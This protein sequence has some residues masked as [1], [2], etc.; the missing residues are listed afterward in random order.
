M[1]IFV[2]AHF[3]AAVFIEII[4]ATK[5]IICILCISWRPRELNIIDLNKCGPRVKTSVAVCRCFSGG[6]VCVSVPPWLKHTNDVCV[7][8]SWRENGEPSFIL[9]ALFFHR[10]VDT[11]TTDSA[12]WYQCRSLVQAL[13]RLHNAF[14]DVIETSFLKEPRVSTSPPAWDVPDKFV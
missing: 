12:G 9:L 7:Q 6:L 10:T 3:A 2:H 5:R 11:L 1:C 14:C 4:F 8:T 13:G